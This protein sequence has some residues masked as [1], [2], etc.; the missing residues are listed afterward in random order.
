MNSEPLDFGVRKRAASRGNPRKDVCTSRVVRGSPPNPFQGSFF[1][2]DP[3]SVEEDGVNMV[4]IDL[5]NRSFDH[6]Q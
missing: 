5:R 1:S 2:E 4:E 3:A 6:F